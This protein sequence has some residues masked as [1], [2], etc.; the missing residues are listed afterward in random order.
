[1]QACKLSL[2]N[3]QIIEAVKIPNMN[4]WLQLQIILNQWQDLQGAW[5]NQETYGVTAPILLG[6]DQATLFPH[7]ARNPTGELIQAN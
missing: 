1:M 3:D 2:N 4:F 5:A 6:A 7:A